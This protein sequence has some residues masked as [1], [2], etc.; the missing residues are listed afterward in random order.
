MA[1][2]TEINFDGEV[3]RVKASGSDESLE[4][5]K[6]YS[7]EVI[8]AAMR[9]DAEKIL[10][11]ERQL[12]YRLNIADTLE[13]SDIQANALPVPAKIAIVYNPEYSKTV[14]FWETAATNRGF[15][16]Q[17]FTSLEEA[18]NWLIKD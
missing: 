11:D 6:N 8:A 13:L 5:P 16:V 4:D 1:I 14:E 10:C 7:M 17:T 2:K 9:Y 12:E 3:L 18:E 15:P